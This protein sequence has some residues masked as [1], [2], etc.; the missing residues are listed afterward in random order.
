MY[1]YLHILSFK[2]AAKIRDKV[3]LDWK[4]IPDAGKNGDEKDKLE[5]ESVCVQ[6]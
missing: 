2:F 5:D 4:K 6:S 1:V 3:K